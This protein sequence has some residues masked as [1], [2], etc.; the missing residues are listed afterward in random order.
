MF[1]ALS[2]LVQKTKRSKRALPTNTD[3][4]ALKKPDSLRPLSSRP[5]V[6]AR[7]D[8]VVADLQRD[9]RCK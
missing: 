9:P 3:L 7:V 6:S 5:P 8:V 1:R 4:P 2:R